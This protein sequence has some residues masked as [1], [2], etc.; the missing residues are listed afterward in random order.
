V[1][2]GDRRTDG[3]A[4]LDEAPRPGQ[5]GLKAFDAEAGVAQGRV[6]LGAAEG[7]VSPDVIGQQ[8]GAAHEC[9]FEGEHAA[10]LEHAVDL[11]DGRRPLTDVM[12][13]AEEEGRL[14]ARVGQRQVRGVAADQ[15]DPAGPP[16]RPR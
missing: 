7:H 4:G 2:Y 1:T 8:A 14:E 12:Q 6:E 5:G 11:R 16:A 3:S 9:L 10:G 15:F 13:H